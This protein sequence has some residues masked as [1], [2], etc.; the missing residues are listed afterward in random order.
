MKPPHPER[1]TDGNRVGTPIEI[2]NGLK[3]SIKRPIEAIAITTSLADVWVPALTSAVYL[4]IELEVVNID[5]TND[6]T[7]S[8][9]GVDYG[10]DEGAINKSFATSIVIPAGEVGFRIGPYRIWGDDAIM[11]QASANGDLVLHIYIVEEGVAAA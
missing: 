4:D 10:N 5:G 9:L 7:L 2:L 6:A 1:D 11:A 3:S 8:A